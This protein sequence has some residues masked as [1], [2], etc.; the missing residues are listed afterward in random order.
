[1]KIILFENSATDV[2]ISRITYAKYLKNRGFDVTVVCQ[3]NESLASKCSLIGIEYFVL[4]NIK[5]LNPFW[6]VFNIIKIYQYA[7]RNNITHIHCFRFHPILIGS[8]ACIGT[9]VKVINHITG[10]G[11]Y[12]LKK[13]LKDKFV[14]SLIKF[15]YRFS[16]RVLKSHVIV[17]NPDDKLELSIKCQV[18]YGSGVDESRF[19]QK[20]PANLMI[21]SK[22]SSFDQIFLFASRLLK[23]KGILNLVQAFSY[24]QKSTKQKVALIIAGL[25]DPG[26]PDSISE[27]QYQDIGRIENIYTVGRVDN[28]NDY[29]KIATF[30]VFPSVYRE[31]VP[32]FLI[33]SLAMAKPIITTNTPGNK[34]VFYENGILI[35]GNTEKEIL[36]S[37]HDIQLLNYHDACLNSKLLFDQKFSQK[38]IYRQLFEQL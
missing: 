36:K 17:Q 35:N 20:I 8:L 12:F 24:F 21:T 34:E 28:V 4:N 10:L 30:S 3:F 33:E 26:N 6:I 23:S 38:I 37:F 32:R 19:N 31:G 2:L 14:A 1:M 18:I 7:V 16:S 15:F 25:P 11:T 5:S 22:Y 13:T 27:R 29:L 9:K